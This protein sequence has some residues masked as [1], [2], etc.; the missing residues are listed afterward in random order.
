MDASCPGAGIGNASLPPIPFPNCY[1]FNT[2][3]QETST[4]SG[5]SWLR[6]EDEEAV[7]GCC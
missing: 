3:L 1:E 2:C 5:G 7:S 4:G 6:R